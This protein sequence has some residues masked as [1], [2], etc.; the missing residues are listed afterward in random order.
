MFIYLLKWKVL[1]EFRQIATL[2]WQFA[3]LGWQF[4]TLGW[5]FAALGW[6]ITGIHLVLSVSKGNN[7]D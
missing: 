4:A 3:T 2:G 5:Q 1:N 6:Q 7:S